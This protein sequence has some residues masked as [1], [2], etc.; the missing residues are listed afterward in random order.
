MLSQKQIEEVVKAVSE[1][2]SFSEVERRVWVSRQTVSRISERLGLNTS[3]FT[4]GRGESNPRYK[5]G[6]HCDPQLCKCGREKDYRSKSCAICTHRGF[7]KS[8]EKLFSDEDVIRAVKD[9]DTY[10]KAARSIGIERPALTRAADRLGLDI[11]HFRKGRGRPYTHEELFREGHKGRVAVNSRFY[12]LDPSKYYCV[13]C[14]Q[15]PIWNGKKL[16]LE[17]DHVNGDKTDNR[18]VNLRW[19][20]PN[21]HTQQPTA[22]GG[23][24]HRYRD[25]KQN[26]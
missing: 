15:G 9:N 1:C 7:S 5:H 11:S 19:L 24:Y 20:C 4:M 6:K 22:R 16:K 23:N 25:K 14:S 3:H 2:R 21:C 26:V 18:V 13:L 10:L 12:K 17:V 8:G